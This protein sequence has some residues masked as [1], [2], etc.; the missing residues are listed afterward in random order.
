[1][2]GRDRVVRVE[3]ASTLT[4]SPAPHKKTLAA[5]LD[6]GKVHVLRGLLLRSSTRTPQST[7]AQRACSAPRAQHGEKKISVSIRF[8]CVS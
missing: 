5:E 3:I 2:F 8:P 1:M 7:L 6:H 4:A